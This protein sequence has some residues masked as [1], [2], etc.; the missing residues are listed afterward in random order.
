MKTFS[1]QK[2]REMFRG[3]HTEPCDGI[4]M[5]WAQ[6]K[7][8]MSIYPLFCECDLGEGAKRKALKTGRF[9]PLVPHKDIERFEYLP[10]T[11]EKE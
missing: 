7:G 1:G 8:R 6:I 3:K 9:L 10:T 2:F 4:K 11:K 5:I